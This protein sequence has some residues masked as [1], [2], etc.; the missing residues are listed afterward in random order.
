MIDSGHCCGCRGRSVIMLARKRVA[1]D[2]R[3]VVNFELRVK[4]GQRA[5]AKQGPGEVK[6]S[7]MW[8]WRAATNVN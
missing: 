4:N 1:S 3:K 2:D 5:C 7:V 8:G 6:Y